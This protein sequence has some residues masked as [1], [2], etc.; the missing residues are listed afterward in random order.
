MR[1]G[2]LFT[3]P[4]SLCSSPPSLPAHDA[5]AYQCLRKSI[6]LR[7]G[8]ASTRTSQRCSSGPVGAVIWLVWFF[9]YTQDKVLPLCPPPLISSSRVLLQPHKRTL[10]LHFE[11]KKSR[12]A[13]FWLL[14][15]PTV[16]AGSFTVGL[17]FPTM[18]GVGGVVS[19]FV[20]WAPCFYDI[21]FLVV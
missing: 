16:I 5:A 15:Y 19:G 18:L 17:M 13:F 14:Q 9:H 21:L 1:W 7:L 4:S 3:A 11:P 10:V 20:S 6:V 8:P 2:K 12:L